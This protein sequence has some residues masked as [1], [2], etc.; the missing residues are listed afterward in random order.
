VTPFSQRV[1]EGL[2]RSGMTLRELCRAVSLDPSFFSKVLAGKRS[3]PA[4][5][6]VLRRIASAL[7]LD[8]ADLIVSAGRIP[9]EWQGMWTDPELFARVHRLA[10]GG[11]LAAALP[12]PELS[13]PERKS[14][15][16][17][18]KTEAPRRLTRSESL[19]EELL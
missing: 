2:K 17:S 9:S 5:E 13:A 7:S 12:R 8:A 10:S 3:P 14:F 16:A 18:P 19:S 1:G 4:E 15:R 6:E 11:L